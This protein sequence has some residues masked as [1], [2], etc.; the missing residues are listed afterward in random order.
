M[1]GEHCTF[2]VVSEHAS[3]GPGDN[4]SSRNASRIYCVCKFLDKHF[5]AFCQRAANQRMR[6]NRK[7]YSEPITAAAVTIDSANYA[8]IN[9]HLRFRCSFISLGLVMI[10]R[11]TRNATIVPASPKPITPSK[12][13]PKTCG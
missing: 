11:T 10:C 6:A 13:M 7:T 12:G 1:T 4:R 8:I 9:L 2:F 3:C 5:C